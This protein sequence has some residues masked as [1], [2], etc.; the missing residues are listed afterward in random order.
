MLQLMMMSVSFTCGGDLGVSSCS[1]QPVLCGLRALDRASLPLDGATSLILSEKVGFLFE[2]EGR[3]LCFDAE[4]G[5]DEG[6]LTL[7]AYL[8]GV[9][10][11]IFG[12]ADGQRP[13]PVSYV[14][15]CLFLVI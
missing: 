11:L 4:P 15:C 13:R 14:S 7:L 1:G 8:L 3:C 5:N 10:S 6:W 2:S 9:S 12:Q